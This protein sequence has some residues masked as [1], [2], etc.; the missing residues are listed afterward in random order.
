MFSGTF[1][2]Q[3]VMYVLVILESFLTLRVVLKILVANPDAVFVSGIYSLTNVFTKP[4]SGMFQSAS[5][6]VY[7]HV[8]FS[9]IF[10][11][12][13]YAFLGYAVISFIDMVSRK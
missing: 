8:E 7:A 2:K 12:L 5:Q 13:M 4:F 9:T 6:G 1:I 3:L 10:G 11:M